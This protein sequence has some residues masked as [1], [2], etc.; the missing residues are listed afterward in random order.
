MPDRL[1]GEKQI[2]Q[3]KNEVENALISQGITDSQSFLQS[4]LAKSKVIGLENLEDADD[5]AQLRKVKK[6][7]DRTYRNVLSNFPSR[8]EERLKT[9]I[10]PKNTT[11]RS[12]S[13][14]RAKSNRHLSDPYAPQEQEESDPA[15]KSSKASLVSKA[16]GLILAPVALWVAAETVVVAR[17][18]IDPI[19]YPQESSPHLVYT[20]DG[21]E[22]RDPKSW[23]TS[24]SELELTDFST[25][26][27]QALIASEDRR[28]Y[29]HN[30]FDFRGTAR[31]LLRTVSGNQQGGSTIT[32]QVAKKLFIEQQQSDLHSLRK[33]LQQIIL[34]GRLER[35]YDKDEILQTYLNRIY[36]GHQRGGALIGFEEAAQ[37]YFGKSAR[38]LNISESATLVGMLPSPNTANPINNLKLAR[39]MRNIRIEQMLDLAIITQEEAKQALDSEI[40]IKTQSRSYPETLAP[41]AYDR[42]MTELATIV[43][44]NPAKSG[45]FIIETTLN[46][47]YQLAAE[48]TLKTELQIK[49]VEK[50]Y[51]EGALVTI[52]NQTGAILALVGGE[53]ANYPVNFASDVK[54]SLA[55][56]FKL[57]PYTVAIAEGFSPSDLNYLVLLGK[58]KTAIQ[59]L[60]VIRAIAI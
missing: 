29:Q 26:L 55:S 34:A 3:K 47:D 18:K 38:D 44:E 2:Q 10:F 15:K 51:N 58:G 48:Q 32:Q 16:L 36:L 40:E 52:D 39:R 43:G 53:G 13:R 9:N 54:L 49:G 59:F 41:Y 31:A 4:Y 21:R 12:Y 7:F 46:N 50:G 8:L 27:Q 5:L 60:L 33:K 25:V 42:A 14:F 57:I 56:T 20:E 37:F 1:A 23:K 30:G 19:P 35:N 17:I 45:Q 24:S 11:N 28:F 22:L 6:D